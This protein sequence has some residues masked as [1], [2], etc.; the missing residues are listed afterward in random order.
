MWWITIL[1][2]LFFTILI[3]VSLY[4][5]KIYDL[6]HIQKDDLGKIKW[7]PRIAKCPDYWDVTTDA[8]GE[9]TC[10]PK[11][12]GL[13]VGRCGTDNLCDSSGK[14]FGC[15]SFDIYD[16]DKATRQD[17]RDQRQKAW[18]CR[19]KWDGIYG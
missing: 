15:N 16:Q 18:K 9:E 4:R 1:I 2:V 13:N 5:N 7:P 12:S 8:N 6:T 10:A 17:K 14:Y 19:V 3:T 11:Y